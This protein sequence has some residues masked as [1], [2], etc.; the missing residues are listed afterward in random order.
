MIEFERLWALALLPLP[1]AA[2]LLLPA[3]P[4]RAALRIPASV[5]GHLA[6]LTGAA[7]GGRIALPRGAVPLVLGWLALVTALAGPFS[8]GAPLLEP[9]GRDLLIAIDL[10]A[11]MA[12]RM[13]AADGAAARQA[14]VVRHNLRDFIGR[15]QGDRIGLIGFASKAYL[16]APLGFDTRAA[17]AVLDELGI[18]LPGRRTDLGQAIGLAV[19]VFR[20]QPA[21]DRILLIVSDGETNAGD[22]AARDAARLAAGERIAIHTIGFAGEIES[23]NADFLRAIAAETGGRYFEAASPAALEAAHREIARLE[24]VSRKTRQ[25]TSDWSWVPLAVALAA[26]AW[27]GWLEVRDP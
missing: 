22:I 16:V 8:K 20:R 13:A 18:G 12:E 14:D 19:Q 7:G 4:A 15:R 10:S 17:A 2:W 25:L 3:L 11:S 21:G 1:I 27:T 24:P 26:L 6:A 23:G 9:T 5:R